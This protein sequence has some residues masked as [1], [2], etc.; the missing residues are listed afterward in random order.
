MCTKSALVSYP[1]VVG[2]P[3]A[4]RH[5]GVGLSTQTQ[6]LCWRSSGSSPSRHVRTE[7]ISEAVGLYSSSAFFSSSSVFQGA[8]LHGER[9]DLPAGRRPSGSRLHSYTR[10]NPDVLPDRSLT[11]CG[12]IFCVS[13]INRQA[14]TG[15]PPTDEKEKIVWVR[16]E[17]ADVNG[18][19][20]SSF[21]FYYC[22]LFFKLSVPDTARNPEFLEMHSS[23]A[24]PPLCLMVGYTDGM[25]IWSVSVS[26]A[27]NK[28]GGNVTLPFLVVSLVTSV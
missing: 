4:R 28:P 27:S 23:A 6:S 7:K 20:V 12:S 10:S 25:Q 3:N 5:D 9:G 13:P 8:V 24:E 21:S 15:A 1:G 11:L 14:Y 17:K 16:F 22:S 19:V 26:P 18:E 2:V